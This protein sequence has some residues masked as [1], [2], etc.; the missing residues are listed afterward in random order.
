MKVVVYTAI[1]N[2]YDKLRN[3]VDIPYD[4]IAYIDD[5]SI[6]PANTNWQI[7]SIPEEIAGLSM[8]DQINYLKHMPHKLFPEYDISVWEDGKV[9]INKNIQSL[10]DLDYEDNKFLS[11]KH[12]ERQNI[13]DEIDI[14]RKWKWEKKETCDKLE[15]NINK[16]DFLK[17]M[18][19]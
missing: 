14:L 9:S 17:I 19:L 3:H 10:L 5:K 13:F 15:Q 4:F 8:F 6:I 11:N 7:R 18:V 2:G 1:L 12:P 16:K